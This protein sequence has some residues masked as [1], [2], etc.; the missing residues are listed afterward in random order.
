MSRG[1]STFAILFIAGETSKPNI[2]VP[3]ATP[4]PECCVILPLFGNSDYVANPDDFKQD[5]TGY[6]NYYD[7]S[8]I[9]TVDLII[10]KSVNCDF[11]DQHT[12]ID[13][14]YGIYKALGVEVI[15]GL[16]YISIKKI[17]WSQILIDFGPGVYRIQTNE[18][19]IFA[20][21]TV[22]HD[23][24]FEYDLREFSVN[25]ADQ[26]VFFKTTNSGLLGDRFD[27]TRRFAFPA[28]WEDGIRLPGRFGFDHSDY[29]KT[30]HK[31][32]S[33]KKVFTT[34]TREEKYEFRGLPLAEGPRKYFANELM[35]A[36]LVEVTDYSK[37]AANTH[38][39]TPVHGAG[40]FGPVY[41]SNTSKANYTVEF[42]N[43]YD[44]FI[45][46]HCV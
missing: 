3:V 4:I 42:T 24:S 14:T 25:L 29:E 36:D 15:N 19:S 32:N 26:T 22:Q 8:A 2:V 43:G 38:I 34:N 13:N 18:T 17:N 6:F 37:N 45:K 33:G 11:E 10:Q 5:E 41:T 7:G 16:N 30:Y 31:F 12:I 9:A 46:H 20:S 44:N 1:D 27:S 28:G 35:Q 21:D 23:Q 39:E 40:E